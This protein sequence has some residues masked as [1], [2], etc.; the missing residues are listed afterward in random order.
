[1]PPKNVVHHERSLHEGR[2][3][4]EA[5]FAF[6]SRSSSRA[7]T[8]LN[9]RNCQGSWWLRWTAIGQDALELVDPLLVTHSALEA[10]AWRIGHELKHPL[11][12]AQEKVCE[13]LGAQNMCADLG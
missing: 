5:H 6:R 10:T 11:H 9:G 13:L 8:F 3:Q 4:I 12:E 1:M 2:G 7:T